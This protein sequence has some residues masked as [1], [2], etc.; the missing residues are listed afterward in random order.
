MSAYVEII[1][2]DSVAGL[3][4]V[5]EHVKVKA[6]YAWNFLIPASKGILLTEENKKL[7]AQ[8][9]ANLEKKAAEQKKLAEDQA[10]SVSNIVLEHTVKTSAD[11]KLFGSV[12]V[13]DVMDILAAK[14]INILKQNVKLVGGNIHNAGEY[15]VEL[16]FY[17][18][19]V[20]NVTLKVIS[21]HPEYSTEN[22]ETLSDANENLSEEDGFN[23]EQNDLE[24]EET[25]SDKE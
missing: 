24:I 1:L 8:E 25:T 12:T 22:K 7:F 13:R 21:N 17:A 5:G 6:G 3:G 23:Q 15:K 2:C 14:E 16:T 10:K 4:K 18:D 9:K 20:A 19:V 11:G